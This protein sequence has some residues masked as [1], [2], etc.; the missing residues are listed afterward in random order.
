MAT[1]PLTIRK[2]DTLIAR[3]DST[4][5]NTVQQ[6]TESG[7]KAETTIRINGKALAITVTPSVKP[8]RVYT[9]YYLD[10]KRTAK[11][12]VADRLLAVAAG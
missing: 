7:T 1:P 10:G 12:A 11:G 6:A 4:E 3:L 8:G 9:L 5:A 2:F